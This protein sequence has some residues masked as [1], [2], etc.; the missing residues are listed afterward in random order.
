ML[1]V[2][3]SSSRSPPLRFPLTVPKGEEE[4][5]K[6][7]REGRCKPCLEGAQLMQ[8]QYNG[9]GHHICGVLAG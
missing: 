7:I 1:L 8:L 4:H 3:F 6:M 2:S 5:L 9:E